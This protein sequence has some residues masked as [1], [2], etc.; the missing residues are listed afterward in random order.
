MPL[1]ERVVFRRQELCSAPP[2]SA[3]ERFRK[4][5][6]LRCRLRRQLD[7]KED[8]LR[9]MSEPDLIFRDADIRLSLDPEQFIS[10][11]TQAKLA[12]DFSE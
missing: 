4:P 10:E 1:F 6:L 8:A 12:Y 5:D 9:G 3:K 7:L 2:L 11:F